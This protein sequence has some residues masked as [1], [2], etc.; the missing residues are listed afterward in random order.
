MAA[1][2]DALFRLVL[3]ASGWL[4]PLAIVSACA[5]LAHP[6]SP[7]AAASQ[8]RFHHFHFRV[9][10]P[11]AAL[12][13]GAQALKGTRV[14]QRG[15]GPGLRVGGGYAFFE[16]V[17]ASDTRSVR[18]GSAERAYVQAREWLL[19]HGIDV[20]DGDIALRSSLA[21][22]FASEA[23]DHVGF[24]A[25]ETR[26]VIDGLRARGVTPVRETT[27]STFVQPGESR[28]DLMP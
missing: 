6:A 14:L 10:D 18:G 22:T 12:S 11:A 15:L 4:R 17:D 7:R 2:I 5:L 13:F 8:V 9:G 24:T 16:R 23:L 20:A 28:G 1:S 19:A 26:A 3:R 21:S 27:A 25:P